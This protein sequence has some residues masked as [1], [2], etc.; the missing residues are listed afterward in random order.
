[1]NRTRHERRA[2]FV[3]E[4]ARLQAIAVDAPVVPEPWPE[5]DEAFREQFIRYVDDLC[6]DELEQREGEFVGAERRRRRGLPMES[7]EY[8]LRVRIPTDRRRVVENILIRTAKC[9][10]PEH[11]KLTRIEREEHGTYAMHL[12]RKKLI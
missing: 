3:Y 9:F 4:A 6:S 12:R 5:R 11:V 10:K 1:M 7:T 2:I 8:I